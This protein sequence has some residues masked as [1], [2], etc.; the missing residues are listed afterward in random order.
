MVNKK[1]FHDIADIGYFYNFIV[2]TIFIL[3]I[4]PQYFSKTNKTVNINLWICF[5]WNFLGLS[6]DSKNK[7]VI[8]LWAQ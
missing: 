8:K 6:K 2:H 4:N 5:T 3:L 7:I 1:P